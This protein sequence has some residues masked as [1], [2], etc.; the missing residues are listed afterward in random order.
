MLAEHDLNG[1]GSRRP[2]RPHSLFTMLIGFDVERALAAARRKLISLYPDVVPPLGPRFS[3]NSQRSGGAGRDRTD[4]LMLAKQLLSQ[5]SYSP[6]CLGQPQPWKRPTI[7]V[8]LGRLERPTSPLS[9]VR[10]NHL[11]YRPET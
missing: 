6:N 1:P 2:K 8:G 9:G 4:D 10:S 3:A 5:L 11:S 7:M